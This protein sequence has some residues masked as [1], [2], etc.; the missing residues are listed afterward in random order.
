MIVLAM[1]APSNSGA[2]QQHQLKGSCTSL[3]TVGTVAARDPNGPEVH[4]I[5]LLQAAAE[6]VLVAPGHLAQRLHLPA[7][8]PAGIMQRNNQHTDH[9]VHSR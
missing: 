8:A 4:T 2:S 1:V 3:S 6:A 5:D 7:A 9:H